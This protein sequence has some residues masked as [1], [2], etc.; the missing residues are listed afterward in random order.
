MKSHNEMKHSFAGHVCLLIS[1]Y[2]LLQKPDVLI[3]IVI[4][5]RGWLSLPD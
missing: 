2:D 4:S 5:V 3:V 1:V